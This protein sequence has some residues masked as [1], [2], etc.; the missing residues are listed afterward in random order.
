VPYRIL[1]AD[2]SD[3]IREVLNEALQDEGYD[4]TEVASGDAV[5]EAFKESNGSVPDLALMDIRMPGKDG[6][7]VLR[8]L[9]SAR[10]SELPIIVMTAFGSASTAIEAMKLGAFDYIAKPF[11]LDEVAVAVERFFERR[12]LSERV[13]RM[14]AEGNKDEILIGDSPAMQDI[15]KTVGRVARSDATVLVLGET[16]TGK[17]LVATVM[18]R[19]S[20]YSAGPLIKVN[21]A[22]LPET[23]LESELFGHEKGAFTGA[24]A[25]RKGR[26]ELANKGTI[27]LDEIGETTLSTQ[28]KLLRVLQERE[29][30]RVGGTN[31][32]KIDT[33]V[34]AATNKDLTREI[35]AGNFREDLF[36]RLNVIAINL[37]P[38][39]E[40]HTD[41]PLLVEHF[42]NKHRYGRSAAPARISQEAMSRLMGHDW[43]GNVRELE[44]TIER[45][46]IMARGGV[47]AA[48]HI[49]FPGQDTRRTVVDVAQAISDGMSL[50]AFLREAEARYVREALR[51]AGGNV[52]VAAGLMGTDAAEAQRRVDESLDA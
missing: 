49:T 17:E 46:V 3:A 16:G 32:I 30:E 51:Q 36:Y 48:E 18:H 47:I 37:P 22:S 14:M 13:V 34:I 15:Y 7:E 42:V 11:E 38:L 31:T 40:R 20:T 39:R 1:I 35:E 44:N 2:D 19:N 52:S 41:I 9:R 24:V 12:D 5:I 25:Q 23:L 27:F 28:K 29:F 43:P 33:R 10:D 50:S 21:C 4:V 6:L 45:A 26:F 8:T